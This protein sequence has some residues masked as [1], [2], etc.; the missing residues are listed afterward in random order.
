MRVKVLG[1]AAGGGFPQWNCGCP[2]C[3][4]LRLGSLRGTARSQAQL[5]VTADQCR[6]FL[7]GAS[8]DLRY[9]IQCTPELQPQAPGRNSPISGIVLTCGDLDHTLGLLL[10]RE[11]QKLSIYSTASVRRILVEH[12][13]MFRLMRRMPGQIAW[14]DI[15]PGS[16]FELVS[17][18]GEPSGLRARFIPLRGD[19]PAYADRTPDLSPPEA[20]SALILQSSSGARL[21]Y[22]PSLPEINEMLLQELAHCSVIILDGTFW[23]DDELIRVEGHGRLATAIGHLPVSGSGGTLARL[24]HLQARRIYAHINNTNPMLDEESA[25]YSEILGNGWEIARDGLELTV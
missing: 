3:R 7:L 21:A 9:Q 6:W 23:T 8:P 12:N 24:S 22:I 14:T 13:T 11:W 15:P 2:N 18:D 1:S 17:P 5:A 20:V 25:E 19:F 16:A 10:L 4:R